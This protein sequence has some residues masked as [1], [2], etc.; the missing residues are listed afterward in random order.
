MKLGVNLALGLQEK[1]FL[2]CPCMERL[3]CTNRHDRLT[4]KMS[5]T[6]LHCTRQ[7]G[8]H[9]SVEWRRQSEEVVMKACQYVGRGCSSSFNWG[10]KRARSF[11]HS[12]DWLVLHCCIITAGIHLF[13]NSCT[14]LK[15]LFWY[16][17]AHRLTTKTLRKH[18]MKVTNY[19]TVDACSQTVALSFSFISFACKT[20]IQVVWSYE[21]RES[22][23]HSCWWVCLVEVSAKCSL[24]GAC[25]GHLPHMALA[26][27]DA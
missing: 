24:L 18:I 4:P 11:S 23:E 25:E 20:T 8:T 10:R 5:R 13:S 15:S 16:L 21:Q 7:E 27:S 1:A 14:F 9:M 2:P 26:Q 22:A 17:L 12:L 3:L 19:L 6:V